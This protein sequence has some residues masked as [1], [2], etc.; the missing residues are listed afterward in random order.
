MTQ[1][2]ANNPCQKS[3]EDTFGAF[4]EG[5]VDD[6]PSLLIEKTSKEI[7]VV[8]DIEG[9]SQQHPHSHARIMIHSKE[10]LQLLQE[11]GEWQKLISLLTSHEYETLYLVDMTKTG[12]IT[13]GKSV[14]D[15]ME[16]I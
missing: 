8:L 10:D 1:T 15:I 12:Q 4:V 11:T 7:G 9:S 6:C 2:T 16:K 14:A 5:W 13:D 3:L